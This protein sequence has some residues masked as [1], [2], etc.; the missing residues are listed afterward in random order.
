MVVESCMAQLTTIMIVP[1]GRTLATDHVRVQFTIWIRSGVVADGFPREYIN[2]EMGTQY[3]LEK[4][5]RLTQL[6]ACPAAPTNLR[7]AGGKIGKLGYAKLA[8]DFGPAD[9][10]KIQRSADGIKFLQ[11]DAIP[12][13]QSSYEDASRTGPEPGH[14]YWYR[15]KAATARGESAVSNVVRVEI[16]Q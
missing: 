4:D 15:V 8:W 10:I 2:T 12:A 6:A 16:P 14:A 3:I 9:E 1:A 7:A 11:I 5:E 13:A